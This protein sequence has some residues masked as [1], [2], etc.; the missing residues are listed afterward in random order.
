MIMKYLVLFICCITMPLLG[1]DEKMK[2]I[3]ELDR[4]MKD[5]GIGYCAIFENQLAIRYIKY[6]NNS[7]HT[8]DSKPPTPAHKRKKSK[9]HS[10][11]KHRRG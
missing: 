4:M 2:A 1:M 7:G 6:T 10:K 3:D 5:L 11:K 9:K 8:R